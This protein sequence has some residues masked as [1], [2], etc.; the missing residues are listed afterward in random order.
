VKPIKILVEKHP[1]GYVAYPLGVKG[2]VVG[3]GDTYEEALSLFLAEKRRPASS[4]LRE[5]YGL[6]H[7]R[8]GILEQEAI[9]TRILEAVYEDGVLRPLE[10]PGLE[11]H[12]R[13]L[14][15]IR[16][17]PEGQASPA[18][19]AWHRVYEGLP[20]DEIAEIEAIAL[21]RSH[22]SRDKR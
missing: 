7:W 20:E 11:E 19:E 5:S 21:D 9:V 13:V 22:F 15:E 2:V 4:A 14:L 8:A 6:A 3:Q 12:Q 16:T 10:D 1:D 18:L 17:Q